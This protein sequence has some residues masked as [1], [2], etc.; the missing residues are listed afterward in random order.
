[1]Y[2]LYTFNFTDPSSRLSMFTL[3]FSRCTD[4]VSFISLLTDASTNSSSVFATFWVPRYDFIIAWNVGPV[5]IK[6]AYLP[7]STILPSFMT[8]MLS[9]NSVNCN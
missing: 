7:D 2:A 4:I 8:R 9:A 3:D 6:S 1:M 5:S